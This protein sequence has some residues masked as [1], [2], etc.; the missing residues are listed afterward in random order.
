MIAPAFL[1]GTFLY[2]AKIDPFTYVSWVVTVVVSVVLHELG[3][4]VAALRQGD[5]T[6]RTSGHMTLNPLVHMGGLSLFLLFVIGIAWGMMPVNPSR[7]RSRHWP[8]WS[9]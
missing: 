8:R 5:D 9:T 4:G 3:H 2:M 1:E 6:P 7:F